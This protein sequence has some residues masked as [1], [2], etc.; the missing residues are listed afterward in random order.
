[1]VIQGW[2]GKRGLRN[3]VA[4]NWLHECGGLSYSSPAE[5]ELQ[6]ATLI[7]IVTARDQG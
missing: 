1:M 6:K 2:M 7:L 3:D 5:E 4:V